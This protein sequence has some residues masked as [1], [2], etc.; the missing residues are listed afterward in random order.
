MKTIIALKLIFRRIRTSGNA[1]RKQISAKQKREFH[2][3]HS[4]FPWIF[5]Q[6]TA[7]DRIMIHLNDS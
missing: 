4:D 7:T 1:A 2:H 6:D 3:F 5:D